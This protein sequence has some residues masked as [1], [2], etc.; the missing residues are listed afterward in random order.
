MNPVN[1]CDPMAFPLILPSGSNVQTPLSQ[2]FYSPN[3]HQASRGPAAEGPCLTVFEGCMLLYI[4][5]LMV[6]IK[7]LSEP[8]GKFQTCTVVKIN[9]AVH[10]T[11]VSQTLTH[12]SVLSII[13]SPFSSMEIYTSFGAYTD[14]VVSY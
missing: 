4:L 12:L 9:T 3:M 1:F 11:T 10:S 5:Q 8:T 14:V 6:L 7:T 13:M 2:Y